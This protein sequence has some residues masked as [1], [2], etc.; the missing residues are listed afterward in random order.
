MTCNCRYC[1]FLVC[2]TVED[3]GR[4]IEC[5]RCS[6]TIRLP[7]KLASI[8]ALKRARRKDPVG[9]SMEI[10]GFLLVPF[11]FPWGLVAGA[12]VIYFGW[13]RSTMLACSNCGTEIKDK[14]ASNCPK[15][16]SHFGSE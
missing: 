4:D 11:L 12:T 5:S 7:G 8:A 6:Q 9:L 14:T 15:C 3:I 13:R 16:K 10:G 1:G 2:Y